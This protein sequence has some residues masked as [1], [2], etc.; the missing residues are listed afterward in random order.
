[1]FRWLKTS[2]RIAMICSILISL[3]TSSVFA[4]VSSEEQ[5]LYQLLNEYRNQYSLPDIP[6]SISLT[7]VAQVHAKDLSNYPPSGQCN[8]HSWSKYGS[9]SSCCYTPDYAQSQCMWNKPKELTSYTGSGYEIS[10]YSSA[11]INAQSALDMWKNSSGHN[12]VMINKD[13]WTNITWN[14]VGVGIYNNYAVIW[15]GKESDPAGTIK[16]S[17]TK[18]NSSLSIA[19][20]L[21]LKLKSDALFNQIESLY[22][23]Y[24]SPKTAT[25]LVDDIYSPLFYRMYDNSY[26][27]ILATYRDG[28]YY[29]FYDQWYYLNTLDEAENTYCNGRCSSSTSNTNISTSSEQISKTEKTYV[30]SQTGLE[31]IANGLRFGERNEAISY[32]RNLN[33]DGNQDWRLSTSAELSEFV[34][35]LAKSSVKP[36]YFGSFDRCTAGIT[37]DGYIALTTDY[38]P[39]GEPLN[40]RGGASIRC[41]RTK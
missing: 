35:A 10:A 32:C 30:D 21:N 1:M 12:N 34:K 20:K 37:T 7:H 3:L 6:L 31:W 41:V 14:A 13:I 16:I 40:F 38:V 11:R 24:F 17:N 23:Q 4:E 39:F 19:D 27:S 22:P 25:E 33:F 9:W 5:K 18:E 29:S 28:L 2:S 8:L 26:N 36:D 15:F